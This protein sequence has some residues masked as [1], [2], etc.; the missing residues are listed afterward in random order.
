MEKRVRIAFVDDEANVLTS[1]RR[2]MLAMLDEWEMA[3]FMSGPDLLMRMTTET[4]DVVVSDMRMPGMDGAAVLDTV[5][6]LYPDTVRVILSGY[7][8]NASVFRTV[9]PAHIYLAKPCSPDSLRKAI[10]S[11]LTLRGLMD[12]N[13]MRR[14][15]GGISSLPSAPKLF[16]DLVEE[17]RSPRSSAATV[18]DL[19]GRDMAMTAELLKLTNS[20]YFTVNAT[21]SA[22]LQAVR[23]LGLEI[24]QTLVLQLGIF[25]Q[26]QGSEDTARMIEALNDYSQA[27][28]NLAER[29]ALAA[30]ESDTMAKAAHCAALL[31]AIGGLVLLHEKRGDYLAAL[32]IV[33]PDHPLHQVEAERFGADHAL[34]GAYLLGLWGF[35]DAIVEAVTYSGRPSQCVSRSNPLLTSLHLARA[36]GPPFPLLPRAKAR[37]L[38]MDTVY[39]TTIA[40]TDPAG[41]WRDATAAAKRKD[42]SND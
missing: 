6:R 18:A 9:G 32:E 8:D 20:S 11:R 1:L 41:H 34:I 24:V 3:F 27:L 40:Q 28:G 13:D 36:L 30:G 37:P 10:R 19:I 7:A 14:L 31:S 5:C 26:F 35:A 22:P 2:S 39:L 33:D 4:F 25:R 42:Q 29:I 17:L 23:I 21:V 12:G 15:L 38:P 16:L